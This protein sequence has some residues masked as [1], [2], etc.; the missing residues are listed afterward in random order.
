VETSSCWLFNQENWLGQ[1]NGE[2]ARQRTSKIC[3]NKAPRFCHILCLLQLLVLLFIPF[4]CISFSYCAIIKNTKCYILEGWVIQER[5]VTSISHPF[6]IASSCTDNVM[7]MSINLCLFVFR[8]TV[9][10][11]VSTCL[12]VVC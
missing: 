8:W 2:E 6:N 5:K 10:T 1:Y 3:S 4:H 9:S 11:T 7:L 12:V